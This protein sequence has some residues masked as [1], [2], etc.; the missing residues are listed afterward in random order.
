MFYRIEVWSNNR[1]IRIQDI[2]GHDPAQAVR[3]TLEILRKKER[4]PVYTSVYV[5]NEN[6]DVW[7]YQYIYR[8]KRYTQRSRRGGRMV[9]HAEQVH[10]IRAGNNTIRGAL[11]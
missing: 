6:G 4:L 10:D 3:I 7:V 2:D 1:P 9:L 5:M 11:K 8:N